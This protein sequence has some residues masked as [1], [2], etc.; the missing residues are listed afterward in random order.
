M[1]FAVAGVVQ[2]SYRTRKYRL[3]RLVFLRAVVH[4][5]KIL[6]PE[7][8]LAHA[9]E[10]ALGLLPERMDTPEAR[11]MVIAIALQES[12]LLHRAQ[13]NGPA[14]GYLQFE[15]G[16]GVRGV[17]THAASKGHIQSVLAALD[18]L[19]NATPADCY[20]AIEHNDILAAAFGRLLLWT[21]PKPLPAQHE[22][23]MAWHYYMATWRPGKPHPGSW[24]DCW[25]QAWQTVTV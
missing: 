6:T 15:L 1:Y 25:E 13:I 16:G 21:H 2:R 20:E 12:R 7:F 23:D 10:P 3:A 5:G 4:L 18:Y 22:T 24:Q 11:A 9:L 17:L 14:R 19:S 8:F